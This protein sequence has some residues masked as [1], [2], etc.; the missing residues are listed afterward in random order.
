MSYQ[1][2]TY[3]EQGGDRYVVADGGSLDIESGGELDIESGGA[4]KIGGV[5]V[6]TTASE[7]NHIADRSVTAASTTAAAT[8]GGVLEVSST[9]STGVGAYKLAAPAAAGYVMDVFC[10]TSTGGV[11]LTS[12]GAT[13]GKDGASGNVLTFKSAN[14]GIRLIAKSATSIYGVCGS[15]AVT[16]T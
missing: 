11:T 10:K 13:I 7:L 6:T 8:F 3:R 14:T 5:A 12:T 2:K 16:C 4:L 1:P 15:T 9:N